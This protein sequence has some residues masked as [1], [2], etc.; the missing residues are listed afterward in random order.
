MME[1]SSERG[2][3]DWWEKVQN[4]REHGRFC[5]VVFHVSS[6]AFPA[7]RNILAATSP[8][9]SSIFNAMNVTKEHVTVPCQNPEVMEQLLRFVYLGKATIDQIIVF[10]LLRLSSTYLLHYLKGCCKDYLQANLNLTN[11]LTVYE[12]ADRYVLHDLKQLAEDYIKK[13]ITFIVVGS[14]LLKY[15]FEQIASFLWNKKWNVDDSSKFVSVCHWVNMDPTSYSKYFSQLLSNIW[16]SQVTV[17]VLQEV[18]DVCPMFNDGQMKKAVFDAMAVQTC[19][20]DEFQEEYQKLLE[21]ENDSQNEVNDNTNTSNTLEDKTETTEEE[22]IT[23]L[24]MVNVTNVEQSK[25]SDDHNTIEV[26]VTANEVSD[27]KCPVLNVQT[28]TEVDEDVNKETDKEMIKDMIETYGDEANDLNEAASS[29]DDSD[30]DYQPE[31]YQEATDKLNVKEEPNA[32]VKRRTRSSASKL[33]KARVPVPRVRIKIKDIPKAAGSKRKQSVP[34]KV[35]RKPGPKR[36]VRREDSEIDTDDE[37]GATSERKRR[38]LN[39]KRLLNQSFVCELC[40]FK[41]SS[42]E[43]FKKHEIQ[44]HKDGVVFKCH[45]CDYESSW[46]REFYRH[47]KQHYKGPPYDCEEEDCDYVADRIQFLLLHRMKHTNERPFE[48]TVCNSKFRNKWTLTTHLKIHTGK[49]SNFKY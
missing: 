24:A 44:A 33:K 37:D 29:H 46:N 27:G 15:S 3:E 28:N 10:D 6:K 20:P 19:M 7:H 34:M 48:C 13:N 17:Q 16:L 49:I 1:F 25:I 4:Q 22:Q 23:N 12:Y 35:R 32:P 43:R 41:T 40:C 30:P 47:M 14:E 18:F 9:F 2:D 39:R 5:D 21:V 8:Y 45:R 38:K 11:C 42:E 36:R 31:I 26:G